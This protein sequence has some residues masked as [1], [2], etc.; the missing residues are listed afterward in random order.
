MR[1]PRGFTLVELMTVIAIV[2]VIVALSVDIG[3]ASATPSTS[4]DRIAG[5]L[6]FARVRS[7]ATRTIHRVQVESQTVSLWRATTTGLSAPTGWERIQI[8]SIPKSTKVWNAQTTVAA[9]PTGGPVENAAL[10]FTID[11]K[12]DGSTTGG[13]I[14]VTDRRNRKKSRVLVYR[15]TGGTYIREGW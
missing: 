4:S 13:T 11:F 12:P 2:G 9:T 14:Y 15:A 10:L 1:A 8:E 6:G 5:T 3:G 7:L